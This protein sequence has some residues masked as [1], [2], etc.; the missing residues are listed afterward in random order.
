MLPMIGARIWGY[1]HKHIVAACRDALDFPRGP[2]TADLV[3]IGIFCM[4]RPYRKLL[5]NPARSPVRVVG[6][7]V[8]RPT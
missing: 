2:V 3:S 1:E 6:G 7:A 8:G 4:C 5:R